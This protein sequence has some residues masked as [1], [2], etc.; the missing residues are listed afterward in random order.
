MY[1]SP[2]EI[3]LGE[4]Q[5]PF[6]STDL[7]KIDVADI[8]KKRPLIQPQILFAENVLPIQHGYASLGTFTNDHPNG[9]IGVDNAIDGDQ[10]L[11]EECTLV[12]G[13]DELQY[14]IA[15][16]G[17]RY[18]YRPTHE[19]NFTF[20]GWSIFT[21]P[22]YFKDSAGT[23]YPEL[24]RGVF[25][26]TAVV[27]GHTYYALSGIGVYEF[28]ADATTK[29]AYT[30]LLGLSPGAILGITAA[31][32]YLIAFDADTVYWDAPQT[33]LDFNPAIGGAG[34]AQISY[35]KGKIVC[36]YPIANGFIVYA[37]GNAVAAQFS[38]NPSVPWV[39]REIPGSGGIGEPRN[40]ASAS[41][42]S[43]QIAWTTKGLQELSTQRA[44][45]L[46][47]EFTDFVRKNTLQTFNFTS[48]LVASTHYAA[49]PLFV[50]PEILG[51]R[52]ITFSLGVTEADANV[53]SLYINR[54][55]QAFIYDRDLKRWGKL[56]TD[57]LALFYAAANSGYELYTYDEAEVMANT[58]NG[59]TNVTY[60]TYGDLI[61][62]GERPLGDLLY[63]DT[64]GKAYNFFPVDLPEF[65]TDMQAILIAGHVALARHKQTQVHEVTASEAT[66]VAAN[67]YA[68]GSND[69]SGRLLLFTPF[70]P[71]AA[72]ITST[73]SY[74]FRARLRKTFLRFAFGFG[75]RFNLKNILFRVQDSAGR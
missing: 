34:S 6:L 58:Y 27:R 47:P 32:N 60:S 26:T 74:G 46:L 63:M 14:Y 16:W 49:H 59:L 64:L 73:G 70:T 7:P 13:P 22:R 24:P 39:F 29:L 18:F 17:S 75:G 68:F 40:V 33:P 15:R 53:N 38:G 69:P 42:E 65:S 25:S 55:L 71:A 4:Q 37:E 72:G 2:F 20:P 62:P 9:D 57:H 56:R 44:D 3:N 51:S 11:L 43:S 21:T 66:T 35:L 8:G 45:N 23:D 36:V 54:R 67:F 52:Y 48:K 31:S 5:I 10:R 12:L 50:Y 28:D 1:G 61:Q 30:E 41:G 19:P